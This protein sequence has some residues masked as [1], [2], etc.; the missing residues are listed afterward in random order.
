MKQNS[1]KN[2]NQLSLIDNQLVMPSTSVENLLQTSFVMQNKPNVKIG[3]V[4]P[5][6]AIINDY[7][8]I[9]GLVK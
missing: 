2:N 5:S 3:K 9:C 4:N 6:I 7:E 8:E 1:N